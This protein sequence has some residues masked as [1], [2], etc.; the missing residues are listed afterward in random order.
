MHSPDREQESRGR[1]VED[2][3]ILIQ[4]FSNYISALLSPKTVKEYLK[5]VRAWAEWWRKPVELFN[6][7][8][9]DD[10]TFYET[11][12]G[13]KATSISR[14]RSSIK[15]FFQYLRRKKLVEH[16]PAKD[17]EKIRKPKTLPVFLTEDETAILY[18]RI[19]NARQRAMVTLLYECG[20]RNAELRN[21]LVEDMAGGFVHVRQGK[22]DKE[23]YVPISDEAMKI[24]E[25]W[26]AERPKDSRYLISSELGNPLPERTVQKTI[27]SLARDIPKHVTPHTLRHSIA[28][29]L[30]NRGVDLRD[31]QEF[32][33]HDSI[34]TTRRYVHVAKEALR[35][36]VLR[37]HPC[38]DVKPQLP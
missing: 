36:R 35:R 28:T 25:A 9:W 23:R 34:E 33:G 17:C 30:H 18:K 5:D 10:W 19:K 20:L 7:D 37:A 13:V 6:Q 21:L 31:I 27:L 26:L 1:V 22:R 11:E 8:E 16:D 24:V 3:E 32:L 15:R 2:T 4:G 38:G 14:H 12:R 29:H